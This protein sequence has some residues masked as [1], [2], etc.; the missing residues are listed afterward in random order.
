MNMYH[1]PTAWVSVLCLL[2][3]QEGVDHLL[4]ANPPAVALREV[5]APRTVFSRPH[6]QRTDSIGARRNSESLAHHTDFDCKISNR[7][8]L[9]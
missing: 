2:G 9:E 8:V 3:M 5:V 6:R 7:L 1:N 4:L